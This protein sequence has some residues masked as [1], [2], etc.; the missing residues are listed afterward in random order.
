LGSSN[1]SPFTLPIMALGCN[2]LQEKL[3]S[4]GPTTLQRTQASPKDLRRFGA[5]S[6]ALYSRDA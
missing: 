3:E 2:G 6:E 4:K 1:E 5:F